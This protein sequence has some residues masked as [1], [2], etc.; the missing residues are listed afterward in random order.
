MNLFTF[1]RSYILYLYYWHTIKPVGGDNKKPSRFS[2]FCIVSG[3]FLIGLM[4]IWVMIYNMFPEHTSSFYD[5]LAKI[6]GRT[7]THKG[8]INVGFF[9]LMTLLTTLS[10]YL[11]CCFRI[12]FEKIPERLQNYHFL[13]EFS[14]YKVLAPFFLPL[15]VFFISVLFS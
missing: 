1:L 3:L 6:F 13:S 11:V 14:R 9:L 12:P 7:E 8:T 15:L 2:G 10:S 4:G 5:W